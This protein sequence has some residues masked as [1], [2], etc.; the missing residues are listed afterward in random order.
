MPYCKKCGAEYS[1][2]SKF[3]SKCGTSLTEYKREEW[4]KPREECF[5]ES[6]A[7]R[8]Y[9]G[10]ISFGIFLIIIAYIFITNPWIPSD[11]FDWTDKLGQGIFQPS[12]RLIF[13]FAFFLGLIGVSNFI[14]ATV[15]F[16]L[17]QP[18]R[19]PLSDILGGVGLLSFAYFIN[20]YG[21]GLLSWQLALVQSIIVVGLLVIIYGVIVFYFGRR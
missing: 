19:K 18:W 21:Q 2:G 15:R 14:I 1:E 8:D 10:L 6:R 4:R 20:L 13:V 5:G 16:A 3:C 17:K 11:F 12:E 9:L 7:E